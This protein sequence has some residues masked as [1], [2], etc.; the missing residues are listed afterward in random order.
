[1]RGKA[2]VANARLAFE[3]YEKVV[4]RRAA[5]PRSPRQA[6]TRSARCGRRPA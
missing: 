6:R 3:R 1:M 5:G 2:A 4:L